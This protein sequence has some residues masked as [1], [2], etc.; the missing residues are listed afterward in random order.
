M[1]SGLRG[2][3]CW[4]DAPVAQVK[5]GPRDPEW[6]RLSGSPWTHVC[7]DPA[8]LDVYPV[9]GMSRLVH[10]VL[11]LALAGVVVLV[12]VV[13]AANAVVILRTDDAIRT[14]ADDL[15]PAQVVV[16]PGSHVREDGS[17]GPVVAERV[18]AAVALHRAGTVAAVL[19]SGDHGTAGYNETDA[20]RDA[21]LAA[22]VPPDDVFTD[23][24]GFSTWHTMSR[25]RE[26][27]GVETAVVVTQGVYVARAV[28]LGAAAGIDTQGYVVR[29][30]G[31]RGREL[32]A[33][34]RG[35]GESLLRPGVVGGPTIPIT[36]DGRDSWAALPRPADGGSGRP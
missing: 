36:G 23:H 28:D 2:D 1:V 27:F 35:L 33:R 10:R 20:M 3:P 8:R 34:V 25:A 17:L 29:D 5:G 12:A 32:L 24:A 6:N 7:T 30:G 18:E 9:P 22:G 13:A 14:D 21:V 15:R 31:R 19:V 4:G 26:I 16:V 11:R